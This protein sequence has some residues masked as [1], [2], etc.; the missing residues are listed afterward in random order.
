MSKHFQLYEFSKHDIPQSVAEKIEKYQMPE[1]ER[2]R[3]SLNEMNNGDDKMS[4]VIS[5][6]SGYRPKW[7]ELQRGRSGNSQHCYGIESKG[8]VDITCPAI[9]FDDLWEIAK[10]SNYTR[11]CLYPNNQFIHC[12]FKPSDH[13]LYICEDGKTWERLP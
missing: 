5:K 2:M 4:I 7:Y 11:V 6:K 10:E 13:K 3:S 9:Y 8:A 12:D 1:L